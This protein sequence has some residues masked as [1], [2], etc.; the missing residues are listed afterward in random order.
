MGRRSSPPPVRVPTRSSI[1][2]AR[3]ADRR[4]VKRSRSTRPRR[5]APRADRP[6]PFLPSA[7]GR[8]KIRIERIADERNR[9]V[10]PRDPTHLRLTRPRLRGSNTPVVGEASSEGSRSNPDAFFALSKVETPRDT[11][12]FFLNV[13]IARCAKKRALPL[14]ATTGDVHETQER[15]DEESDGALRVVRL[16]DRAGDF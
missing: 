11:A 13:K 12:V 3:F 8:K 10:R 16:P 2:T 6:S 7:V 1:P 9:Q 14:R 5:T 4:A 15:L